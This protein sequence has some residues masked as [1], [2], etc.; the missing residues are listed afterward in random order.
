MFRIDPAELE[1]SNS[2]LLL[3]SN[4]IPSRLTFSLDE[5]IASCFAGMRLGDIPPV[6]CR[7]MITRGDFVLVHAALQQRRFRIYEKVHNGYLLGFVCT[8]AKMRHKGLGTRV[9]KSLIR[10]L[11]RSKGDFVVLNC[12]EDVAGFYSSLGS[13]SLAR[14]AEY[15]RDGRTEIDD[16]PVLGKSIRDGFSL[17]S[18]RCEVFPVGKDF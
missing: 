16:D 11:D 18:L 14:K 1:K 7:A 13:E 12:G 10:Q 17:E 4:Y 3:G 9:T 8:D 5:L 2:L 6:N 15:I